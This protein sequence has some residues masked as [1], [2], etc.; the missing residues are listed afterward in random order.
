M[1]PICAEELLIKPPTRTIGICALTLVPGVVGGSETYVREL[2][3]ALAKS[4]VSKPMVFLPSIARDAHG[5]LPHKVVE[6]YDAKFSTHGRMRSMAQ[7]FAFGGRVLNEL[8]LGTLSGIHFP[9][10][11]PIPRVTSIPSV[12]TI[13]DVQHLTHPMFFSRSE[14]AY[15]MVAYGTSIRHSRF[16]ITISHHAAGAIAE[17]TA[18]DPSTIRV[19]HLG[20]DLT[21]FQ[22][23]KVDQ[24]QNF[25]LYPANNWPHKN[26]VRLFEAFLR[27]R[28]HH[29]DIE[30]VLTG[31]G[32]QAKAMPQGVRVAGHVSTEE[33]TRLYQ[34]ARA[35]VFPSLYEGFGLPPLEA[36]AAD[37][38]VAS[39]NAASLPEVCGDAARLFDPKSIDEMTEAILEVLDKPES[40]IMAGRAQAKKF[41][42]EICAQ[43]H[44]EVYSELVN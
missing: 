25:L 33:M 10:G 23:A 37:C 8:Q 11:I 13:V 27:V 28:V 3:A 38:P 44:M 42:W 9:L 40:L 31:A 6:S 17:H 4:A 43:K 14:R 19:I 30:L 34:T 36:M 29:P 5:G 1:E 2:N 7:A 39:S 22:G 18:A 15:R 32:H 24:R 16:L 41:T 26:H 21:R 20:V 12:A 35:V